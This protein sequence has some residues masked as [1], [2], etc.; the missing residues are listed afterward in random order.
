[1][2]VDASEEVGVLGEVFA[3]LGDYGFLFGDGFGAVE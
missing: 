3:E 1:M 2:S